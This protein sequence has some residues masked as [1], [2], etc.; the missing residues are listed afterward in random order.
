MVNGAL[1][2]ITASGDFRLEQRDALVQL[3]HRK[4]IDV[5]A[6]ELGGGVVLSAGKI[7][8]VHIGKVGRGLPH[9]KPGRRR[10]QPHRIAQ[11]WP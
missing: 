9:V 8:R 6:R 1:N 7:V 11:L 5:L 2:N 10:R 4:G 3:I